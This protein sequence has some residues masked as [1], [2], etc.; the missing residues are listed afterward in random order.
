MNIDDFKAWDAALGLRR[1]VVLFVTL[2]MTWRTFDWAAQFAVQAL[3]GKDAGMVAAAGAILAAV[4][5]PI[6]YLQKAVFSAYIES[7]GDGQ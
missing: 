4:M 6:T 3:Q 2:W 1:S 5:A 7:K